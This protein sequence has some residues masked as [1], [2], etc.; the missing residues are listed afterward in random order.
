MYKTGQFSGNMNLKKIILVFNNSDSMFVKLNSLNNRI[1]ASIFNTPPSN[2]RR[3]K[4][5]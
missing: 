1:D 5:V 3:T 2:T 4:L